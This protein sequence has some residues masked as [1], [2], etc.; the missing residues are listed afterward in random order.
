MELEPGIS[1]VKS[2]SISTR[3]FYFSM[4]TTVL[5]DSFML[6]RGVKQFPVM[7]DEDTICLQLCRYTIYVRS[8]LKVTSSGFQTHS[9][10]DIND[11]ELVHVC[12][13]FSVETYKLF[14]IFV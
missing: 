8:G 4:K 11:I 12:I 3:S 5:F 7:Y 2:K 13:H 1:E 10:N 14:D 9:T 6:S